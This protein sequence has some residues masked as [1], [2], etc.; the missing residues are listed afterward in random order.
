MQEHGVHLHIDASV[1]DYIVREH[2]GANNAESGGGREV[3][4]RI[5]TDVT[6]RV[7]EVLVNYP[8][9]KDLRVTIVGHMSW[10]DKND[11]EGTAEVAVGKWDGVDREWKPKK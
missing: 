11:N 4:R 9:L 3:K 7:A 2:L 1:N 5:D 10:N 6:S 8:Q